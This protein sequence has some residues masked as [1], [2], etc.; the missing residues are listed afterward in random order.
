M[1]LTYVE[2]VAALFRKYMDEADPTWVDETTDVPGMLERGY[3][4]FRDLVSTYDPYYFWASA[5]F[6]VSGAGSIDLTT[7]APILMGSGVLAATPRLH[8]LL[9]VAVLD[10]TSNVLHYI[11]GA[12]NRE[13]LR[14]GTRDRRGY[15]FRAGTTLYFSGEIT[16]T[17]RLEYVPQSLVDWTQ[18]TTGDNEWID[19]LIP[20]HDIIAL[21]AMSEYEL[22][23]G[24][25]NEWSERQ[26]A[27]RGRDLATF[28]ARGA[29]RE[30]RG[31]RRFVR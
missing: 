7:A 1:A 23:D 22:R 30:A 13:E 15:Y 2:H 18:T 11:R 19:D 5:D 8:S 21:L 10:G 24:A 28:F 27:R 17:V 4:Q 20:Y 12:S 16:G 31:R 26:L 6:S 14:V 29:A 25:V 9:K 3:D